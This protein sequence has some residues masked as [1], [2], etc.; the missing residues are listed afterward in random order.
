MANVA[1]YSGTLVDVSAD[2]D[3]YVR[4]PL[5]PAKA[6][7]AKLAARVDAGTITGAE[8]VRELEVSEDFRLR[9]GVDQ[10]LFDEVPA[11]AVLNSALWTSIVTTMTTAVAGGFLTLNAGSSIAGSVVAQVRSYRHFPVFGAYPTYFE[12]PMQLTQAPVANNV[13]EWGPMLASSTTP[14]TDGAFFRLAANGNF[15]VCVV[16]AGGEVESAPIANFAAL[17]GTLTRRY[18]ISINDSKVEFWIDDVLVASLALPT[19]GAAITNSNSLPIAFRTYQNTG[20]SA[21][22]QMK[23]GPVSVHLGDTQMDIPFLDR[24]AAMGRTGLQGQT[25]QASLLQTAQHTNNALP[26]AFAPTN[27][28]TPAGSTGLGGLFIVN[29][30]SLAITTDYI[31]QSYQNPLGSAAIPG[32]M[33]MIR[34]FQLDVVNM[35]VANGA[36]PL[37][38]EIALAF[39]H[40]TLPLTVVADTATAK[41]S[42][43][44]HMGVQALAAAAAVGTVVTPINVK[45][46]V[47]IPVQPGEYIMTLLRFYQYL[48]TATQ[49]FWCAIRFDA[50]WL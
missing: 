15:T 16:G 25:G 9:V 31:I 29:V 30:A 2:R 4:T 13:C 36:T 47:P 8:L 48:S 39:G 28:T 19:T 5:L 34:G 24:L 42:R 10:P 22:Q 35:V 41:A 32:K 50:Y 6:G 14:P 23:V 38:W 40:T 46:D 7:F 43:R 49:A 17:V 45:L 21:A 44:D 20:V 37:V 26:T 12:F 18:I 3:L 11:G 33:L 27:T 1:G